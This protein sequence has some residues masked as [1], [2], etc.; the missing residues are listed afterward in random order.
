[1]G[2]DVNWRW[3]SKYFI[4]NPDKIATGKT[5]TSC[6]SPQNTFIVAHNNQV[7]DFFPLKAQENFSE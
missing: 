2:T 7:M 3:Y 4:V 1:M 5:S 6:T